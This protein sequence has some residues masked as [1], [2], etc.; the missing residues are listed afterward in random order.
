MSTK[1]FYGLGERR[2]FIFGKILKHQRKVEG[3]GKFIKLVDLARAILGAAL[4]RYFPFSLS[5]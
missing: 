4:P 2:D 3:E 5:S 1:D